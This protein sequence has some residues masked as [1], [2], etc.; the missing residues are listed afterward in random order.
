M[1]PEQKAAEEERKKKKELAEARAKYI[2]ER[3]RK[4]RFPMED[5]NLHAED[6]ELGVKPPD[7][8]SKRPALPY[9]LS[10]IVPFHQRGDARKSSVAANASN[11]GNGHWLGN[12]D[13][14]GLITDA[15]HVIISSVVMCVSLM[16][17]IKF[18]NSP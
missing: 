13:T 4:R 7:D 17:N 5:T 16:R 14:R 6:K 18:H 3:L 8:V 12:D 2:A 1:T 9:T 11:F 15:L 10:C